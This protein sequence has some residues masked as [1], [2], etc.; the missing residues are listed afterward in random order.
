MI[1]TLT[2]L[3]ALGGDAEYEARA[4]AIDA[5]IANMKRMQKEINGLNHTIA[6]LRRPNQVII[7]GAA[8]STAAPVIRIAP[9]APATTRLLPSTSCP[10]AGGPRTCCPG[11]IG[12]AGPT[13]PAG[14]RGPQGES[15]S[16]DYEKL[17]LEIAKH[18]YIDVELIDNKGNIVKTVTVRNR[19]TL[20]L[21]LHPVRYEPR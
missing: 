5:K 6:Q 21:N 15:G 8:P 13:G 7:P 2:L 14:E 12:P 9:R 10:P 4:A 1:I 11:P 20:K 16:V 19:G 18:V 3:A 17:A